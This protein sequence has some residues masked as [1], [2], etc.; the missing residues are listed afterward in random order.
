MH[1]AHSEVSF[2]SFHIKPSHPAWHYLLKRQNPIVFPLLCDKDQL[3]KSVGPQEPLSLSAAPL[4]Y[5]L[6]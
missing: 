1:M 4:T 2:V 3:I 5:L 6:V